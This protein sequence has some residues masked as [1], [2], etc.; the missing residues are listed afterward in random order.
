VLGRAVET[1]EGRTFRPAAL[2]ELVQAVDTAFDYR[3]DVTLELHSGERIEGYIFNRNVG[4]TPPYLQ[5]YPSGQTGSRLILYTDIA[6]MIF[7]GE[8][9]ASGKSWESWVKKK[10]AE[11]KAEAARVETEAKARGHL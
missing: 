6:A 8:D 11:R 1:L 2:D 9:T 3:G 10:E 7:S 5:L 4:A